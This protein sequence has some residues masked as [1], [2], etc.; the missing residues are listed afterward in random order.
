MESVSLKTPFDDIIKNCLETPFDDIIKNCLETT[1][2]VLDSFSGKGLVFNPDASY[3]LSE[4]SYHM[5]LLTSLITQEEFKNKKFSVESE[6]YLDVGKRC[7]LYLK[8]INKDV[9]IIEIKY[10]RL[11]YLEITKKRIDKKDIQ[12]AEKN[13]IYNDISEQLKKMDQIDIMKLKKFNYYKTPLNNQPINYYDT[14]CDETYKAL[15]QSGEYAKIHYINTI[16]SK[17]KIGEIY[18]CTIMGIGPVSFFMNKF[19]LC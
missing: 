4:L 10:I 16:K 6:K 11:P 14:I 15:D 18:Y 9:L 7:D 3:G 8:N 5:I 19:K 2:T 1:K 12:L 17:N 13:K